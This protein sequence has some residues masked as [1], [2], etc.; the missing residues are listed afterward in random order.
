MGIKNFYLGFKNKFHSCI[1]NDINIHCDVLIIELNGLFY[2][3][4][5]KIYNE[6][7]KIKKLKRND[8][9]LILFNEICMSLDKIIHKYGE[10][11]KKIFLVVDGVSGMMK[12]IEQRQRRYKN[13]FENKFL[14]KKFYAKIFIFFFKTVF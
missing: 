5:K 6:V 13:S 1:S 8:L 9:Y 3:N 12:N 4:C 7:D 2:N 10:K 11:T 14:K